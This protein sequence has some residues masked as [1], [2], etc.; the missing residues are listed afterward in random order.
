MGFNHERQKVLWSKL[1]ADAYAGE[2]GGYA[3]AAREKAARAHLVLV[4]HDLVLDDVAVDFALL[5]ACEAWVFDDAHRLPETGQE[6]FGRE[7]G[8]FRL[9]HILQLL[10]HSK[11][12]D[13]GLLAALDRVA[14]ACPALPG[15][16]RED[17]RQAAGKVPGAGEAAPEV[18]QQDRQACPE[19]AQ[20]RR[21]PHPLQR[22]AG[23]RVQRLARGRE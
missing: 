15:T 5:P 18:L 10:L 20:G 14:A 7:I 8:F 12:E 16:F 22:Q 11:T 17:A 13:K 2:P 23:D 3:Q 4:T 1:S 19:A 9:R 6:R 21:E